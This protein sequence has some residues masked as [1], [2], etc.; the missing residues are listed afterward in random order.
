MLISDLIKKLE[1]ARSEH[2][3]IDVRVWLYDGQMSPGGCD[4]LYVS[5]KSF[6]FD[7]PNH[8][9]IETQEK[10]LVLE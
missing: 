9:W 3:N 6:R 2:G 5:E 8:R 4:E 7:A 10:Y 1:A